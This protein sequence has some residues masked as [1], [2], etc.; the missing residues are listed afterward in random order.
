[1]SIVKRPNVAALLVV[2]ISLSLSACGGSSSAKSSDLIIAD[3]ATL[4]ALTIEGSGENTT[5]SQVRSASVPGNDGFPVSGFL[6]EHTIFAMIP[7]P[8][9]PWVYV[10]SFNDCGVAELGCWGNARVD[11][12][13]IQPKRLRHISRVFTFDESQLDI[14][15][16]QNDV[17]IEGQH[18]ACAIVSGVISPDGSRLYLQ[19]DDFDLLMIFAINPLTGALTF[20]SEGDQSDVRLH[21]LAMHPQAALV[22]NGSNVL[23]V[24]DDIISFEFNGAGGNGTQVLA[25]GEGASDLL[26]TTEENRHV[27]IFHLDEPLAPVL[28]DGY[29]AGQRGARDVAI[30][31]ARNRLVVVGRNRVTTLSFDGNDITELDVFD[32]QDPDGRDIEYRSVVLT[33]QGEQLQAAVSWFVNDDSNDSGFSGGVSLFDVDADG[34]ITPAATRLTSRASRTLM[35]P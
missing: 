34:V 22:Y 3:G 18:G 12:F 26:L 25:G 28:V 9:R 7:H 23:D 11:L 6:P 33:R 14:S 13:E 2:F 32:M 21:G 24:S 35:R 4:R 30:N 29:D 31:N 16:A 8:S 15:C 19:D 1:M 10:T 5:L 27:R 17:G 20:L